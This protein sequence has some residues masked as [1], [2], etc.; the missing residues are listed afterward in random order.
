MPRNEFDILRIYEEIDHIE[1]KLD[2]DEGYMIRE[3]LHS[4][5]F[6]LESLTGLQRRIILEPKYKEDKIKNVNT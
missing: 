6:H 2:G 4:I 3:N 5:I 1:A